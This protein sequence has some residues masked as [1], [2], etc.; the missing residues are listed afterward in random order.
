MQ[1]F[2]PRALICALTAVGAFGAVSAGT[3]FA[4]AAPEK[5]TEKIEVTGSN[6]KRV[7]AEGPSAVLVI[8]RDE[9]EK[10]GNST[11]ADLLRNLP[12][13][14][15]GTFS[16]STSGG[17]SF[18][19]GTAAIS[20]RGLGP[21]TTLVLVNGRRVANYG[22]G[23]NITQ[24]FVDLNAIP[25]SAIERIE[26]LKD[27][28]SAIYGSDALAGVVNIILRKDFTGVELSTRLGRASE[29]DSE[30]TRYSLSGGY[31]DLAKN[32]FN[33]FAVLDA[34][35]R[36]ATW[37][38]DRSF[39]ANA[40]QAPN[41]GFDL[42]SPTGNPG[43]WLTLGRPGF[44]DNTVFPSCPQADRGLFGGAT[45]CYFNFQRFIYLIPPSTRNAAFVRGIA[46]FTPNLSGF[47]EY[48]YNKNETENS[49]APTP[50]TTTLPVGHNSNP[51]PFS[52][53][54]RYRFTDVGPRLNTITT[55]TTRSLVGLKGSVFGWDWESG[56]IQGKSDTLNAGR[57]YVSQIALNTLT[58]NNIYNFVDNS[59]NSASLVDSLKANPFRKAVSELKAFD[60]KASRE[61]FQLPGGI[62]AVAV[63][64]DSRKESVVDALDP[65]SVAGNIVGSGGA[66]AN[67]SRKLKSLY[68]EFSLPVLKRVESQIAF[69]HEDYS[70]FG[71]T[72]KPKYALSWK[73]LD[74]LLLR[75]SYS[76]GFRAPSL[77]ELYLGGAT[78]FPSFV[79][80]PRCAAYRTAFGA[81]DPRANA[82]CGSA[83]VRSVSGGNAL[84]KP[85]SSKS[86]AAGFVFDPIRDLSIQADWYRIEHTDRVSQPTTAFLLANPTPTTVFRQAQNPIDVLANAPG[87]LRGVASDLGV[88]ISR[89]YQNLSAQFTKGVDLDLRY[90]ISAGEFG[91]FTLTSLT[92]HIITFKVQTLP[93]GALVEN[94][95]TYQFPR[96]TSTNSVAWNRNAWD[97]NLSAQT[98]S[99]FLQA[100]QLVFRNVASYTTLNTQVGYA[101]IKGLRLAVGVNNLADKKPPFSDNENDGYANSTDNPVG[102]Y[103]YISAR[104]NWK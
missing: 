10:S 45:T 71:K 16:E 44:T 7:D 72:T 67:G 5:K 69:R 33:V 74:T 88:G 47:A 43:T 38:R 23:Q 89:I 100:N 86:W 93:G 58:S 84:L 77:S 75:T 91:R 25:P 15:A 12:I 73:A 17:N 29:G 92:S 22:F 78:S 79:D 103:Y 37:A 76:L 6:I 98:R 50:G 65:L 42:R 41:G 64:F 82:V 54:A 13:N 53:T 9:I 94:V 20:L 63:G 21:N 52:V 101:G 104:Y 83:Q 66:T 90:R 31:G 30:E 11:I 36:K 46:D 19:P 55:T 62:A 8:S 99:K 2:K 80:T 40:N 24:S 35:E 68:T 95:G 28:A 96:T 1:N 34:Y 32:K 26:I 59:R 49:A 85:E 4:Q 56:Y 81:T 102:R 48:S 87:E 27:G 14:N 3:V 39:S 51:Y 18:A 57:G 97:A 70:D 60:V 61:L